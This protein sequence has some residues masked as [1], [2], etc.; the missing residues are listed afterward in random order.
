ME[1]VPVQCCLI[2]SCLVPAVLL[3]V[4]IWKQAGLQSC[5][6]SVAPSSAA[7]AAAVAV[8]EAPAVAADGKLCWSAVH[9]PTPLTLVRAP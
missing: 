2:G 3:Q 1:V 6:Q 9:S 8:A 5:K 7:A 4:L